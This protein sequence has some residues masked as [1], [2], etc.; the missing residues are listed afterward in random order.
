MSASGALSRLLDDAQLVKR[1]EDD[2]R[3]RPKLRFEDLEHRD[4]GRV[5]LQNPPPRASGCIVHSLDQLDDVE[6]VDLSRYRHGLSML[7]GWIRGHQP[8]RGDLDG[9]MPRDACSSTAAVD[10]KTGLDSASHAVGRL[11]DLR[12]RGFWHRV[13][14]S[15]P[16]LGT[17]SSADVE[18]TLPFATVSLSKD[19][20]Q[21]ALFVPDVFSARER[22]SNLRRPV[23]GAEGR[24]QQRAC[25]QHR[26]IL[27]ASNR[28]K[29]GQGR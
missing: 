6:F 15:P 18:Y 10:D 22:G 24:E 11:A 13:G 2:S 26:P 17:V 9:K 25:V 7:G 20:L 12:D 14:D 3:S 23:H 5:E 16:D 1:G 8:W 28:T 21:L 4:V 29:V 27:R 19:P